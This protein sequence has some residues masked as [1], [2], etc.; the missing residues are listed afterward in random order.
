MT[1][2]YDFIK[3]Q[4]KNLRGKMSQ[5]AF[6]ERIG[7]APNT[8]SRW[9][10]GVYKPT[11]EDLDKMAREFKVPITHFFPDS[12][13]NDSVAALKLNMVS[14]LTSATAGLTKKDID[15][16]IEYAEFRKA[17]LALDLGKKKKKQQ[18]N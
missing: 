17:K 11:A 8:L 16:V 15:S 6:A 5:E 7:I 2:I 3:T 12:Q 4:I 13:R 10:N 14:A 9:E 1:D 18:A